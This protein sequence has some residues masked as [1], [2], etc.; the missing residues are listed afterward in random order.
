MEAREGAVGALMK[1]TAEDESASDAAVTK[2]AEEVVEPVVELGK[3]SICSTD[4]NPEEVA[5]PAVLMVFVADGCERTMRL[6]RR[7]LG[8]EF[9]RRSKGGFVKVNRV[10]AGSYAEELGIQ[11][12]WCLKE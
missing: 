8:A 12:G 3:E 11:Q 2:T 9:S 4:S 6:C 10:F 5:E 1:K 7:P